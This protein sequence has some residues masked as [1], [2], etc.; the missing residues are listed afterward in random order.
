MRPN[1]SCAV[2]AP[3]S[4]PMPDSEFDPERIFAALTDE[5]VRFVLIGGMAAILHGD[6]GVTV[7]IDI[8]P[9]I[10][11]TNL[12]RLA[13]ALRSLDARI[14]AEG[15]PDGLVFD[16]SGDFFRNLGPDAI[17]N[18]TTQAGDVDLAFTPAGTRGFQDLRQDATVIDIAGLSIPVASLS[19]VIRSKDAADR[20]KDRQ[21][22]PRLRA[23][24]E[25]TQVKRS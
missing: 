12:D 20:P 5:G 7:D 18:L 19:D 11:P 16:C 24:L 2:A 22:L 15:I 4:I 1:S 3:S 9:A 13:I 8:V 6:V 25:R 14:R 10:D 21:A 23:L 17:V